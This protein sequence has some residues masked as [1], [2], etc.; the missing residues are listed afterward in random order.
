M[1]LNLHFGASVTIAFA[2]SHLKL[3]GW[4]NKLLLQEPEFRS[5]CETRRCQLFLSIDAMVF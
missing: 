3:I 5:L 4:Y 1:T 2:D